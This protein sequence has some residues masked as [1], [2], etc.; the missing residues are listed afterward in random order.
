MNKVTTYIGNAT[1]KKI[2]ELA[3]KDEISISE[4]IKHILLNYFKEKEEKK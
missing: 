4:A 1:L 3:A 2:K